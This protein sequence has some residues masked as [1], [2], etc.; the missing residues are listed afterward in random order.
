MPGEENEDEKKRLEGRREK[1]IIIEKN[2]SFKKI[3]KKIAK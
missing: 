1:I 2:G 3:Y